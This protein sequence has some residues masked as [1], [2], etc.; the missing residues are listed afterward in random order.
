MA[1]GGEIDGEGF[2]RADEDGLTRVSNVD[3]N[4][5]GFVVVGLNT[6][7]GNEISAVT[8]FADS[9]VLPHFG[10]PRILR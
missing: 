10:L 7:E 1:P 2:T 4:T 3:L 5:A 9:S 6:L 8:W